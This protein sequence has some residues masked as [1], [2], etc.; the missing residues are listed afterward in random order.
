VAGNLAITGAAVSFGAN[1]Q[2]ADTA[3]VTMSGSTSVFNGSGFNAGSIGLTETISSLAVTGGIFQTGNGAA[4]TVTGTGTFDAS[5]GYVEYLQNS[6]ASAS[7]GGLSLIGMTGTTAGGSAARTGFAV[8]GSG[9]TPLTVGAGGLS[10]DGS[11]LLLQSANAATA[12]ARLVLG[13]GVTTTGSGASSIMTPSGQTGIGRVELSG[14]AGTVSRTF[15]TAAGGA[16]LTIAVPISN[17]IATTAGIVKAGPGVLTLSASNSYTGATTVNAGSLLVNGL[18]AGLGA[19]TVDP[20]ATLG[21]SGSIA[22]AVTVNGFLS[23]GTSPGVLSVAS[24]VLGESSTV[25]MEI[26]DTLPGTQYDQVS[27]TGGLTYG[28]TLSLNLD[29]LFADD[30]PF[31]LFSG[32]TSVSGNLASITSVGSAY[33]GL[34]FTRTDNLWKS[35]AA[36]NGQTLEFNQT[37]GTLVIVPEPGAIA[38]AAIG[39]AAASA[40]ARY[41]RRK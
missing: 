12:Y 23:P 26:N 10:L 9:I 3:A 27:L 29:K 39:I 41:R 22:G 5:T 35:T 25:L 16:N 33:N 31:S 17:G 2:I 28:G 32:F 21:G 8:A 11:N 7:F 40:R 36:P 6:G 19:V 18:L 38:L 20:G 37:T 4:I 14:T 15:T 13:G 24:L 30:T 1:N 34:L